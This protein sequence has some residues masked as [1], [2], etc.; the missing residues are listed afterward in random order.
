VAEL[1][2]EALEMAL[3]HG[4]LRLAA[5]AIEQRLNADTSDELGSRIL[6]AVAGK[7]S[8]PDAGANSSRACSGRCVWSVPTITV[9]VVDKVGVLAMDS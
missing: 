3:R 6:A 9:P 7:R 1:V 4:T 5:C 8:F 2:F